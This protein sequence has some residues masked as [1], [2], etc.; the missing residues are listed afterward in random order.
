MLKILSF[1]LRV[2]PAMSVISRLLPLLI[3]S[4]TTCID[5]YL[6]AICLKKIIRNHTMEMFYL[7]PV[8]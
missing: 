7:H 8:Y 5:P 6:H 4:S 1:Y 2:H 3:S